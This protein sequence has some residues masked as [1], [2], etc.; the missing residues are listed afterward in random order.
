LVAVVI[1][2]AIV[3]SLFRFYLPDVKAYRGEI[4]AFASEVLEQDVRIDS[5]DAK[6]S[7]I[8]PLIT[9]NNVYLLDTHTKNEIV[10]FEQARLTIDLLRS[11]LKMEVVPDSFT[12][13]GVDLGVVRKEDGNFTIQG[14]EIDQLGDQITL[15]ADEEESDELAKWFFQRS[16]LAIK[17][18]RVVFKNDHETDKSIQLDNVNFYL[19]NDGDRHQLTGTVTLP[20]ELGRDLEIAFDFNGNILN[21]SQWFGKVYYQAND[22][23]LVNWGVKP[24]FMFASLEQ[25]MLDIKLW[26]DWKA[27]DITAF[28]ADLNAS[29]FIVNVGKNEKPF[30]IEKLD[31]LV[32]WHTD[33]IGWKLNVKDFQYK[34]DNEVWPASKLAVRYAKQEELIS[35]YSSFLRLEDIKR[36]LIDGKILDDSLKEGLIKIDPSGDLHH[37]YLNYS[38]LEDY[39]KFSLVSEFDGLTL[40]PWGQFPGIENITGKVW[41]NETKGQLKLKSDSAR[42]KI[43][44]IFRENLDL[45]SINGSIDWHH[46]NKAWHLNSRD[47]SAISPDI[48]ANLGFYAMVPDNSASPYLDLQVD[49]DNGNAKQ[50]YKY[51]PVSVMDEELVKWLDK[52]F[53]SGQVTSGGVVFNGR[54]DDFPFRDHSGTLLAD[55]NAKNVNLNY[56]PGWPKIKVLDANL[57]ITGL[58]L[59]IEASN[60]QIYDSYLTDTRVDIES[61][62]A[63]VIK[64]SSKYQGQTRDLAR[65]LVDT[66]I[67]PKA[68]SILDELR[69]SGKSTGNGAL[70]LPLSDKTQQSS[71]F[72]YQADVELKNNELDAWQ[73]VLQVKKITGDLRIKQEGI[74]SDNLRFETLGGQSQAKLYTTTLNDL[75]NIKLSM[76]GEIDTGKISEHVELSMLDRVNGKT[77]WQGILAIG[78]QESPGYFQFFSRLDGVELNLP[79]PLVKVA[80]SEKTLN[81]TAQFPEEEKLPLNIKYGDELSMALIVNLKKGQERP[82]DKGEIIFSF[83][84]EGAESTK[85]QA[86]LPVNNE[87]LIRGRLREFHLDQWLDL[88]NQGDKKQTIGITSLNI[89]VRLDMEYLK[90]LTGDA[91]SPSTERKDPRNIAIFDGDI[92]AFFVNDMHLGH[93]KFKMDRHE[94]G[95]LFKEI[96]VDAPYMQLEG[97]GSWLYRDAKHVTNFL[98]LISTEDLGTMLSKLGYSA[99]M[100]KGVSKAV[101]QAHWFDT[102]DNFSIDKLN[103]SIG[104]IIDDGVLSDVKPGAGRM[105]G[106]FSLAELP[107]RLLLDFSELKQG[108]AF[109][110]IVGQINISEGDAYAETLKIISPIALITIEGRTGLAARDFDQRVVVVPSVSGTLPVISWIAWGG[111]I[112]AL[113]FLLEQVFG[114]Q[115]DSSIATEYTITGSWDNPEIRKIEKAP[116][117]VFPEESANDSEEDDSY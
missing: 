9:F 11:L 66:P 57:E 4:E 113:A 102:P 30:S 117:E 18:S 68:Q 38:F 98:T 106:L 3:I 47:I 92:R 81:V 48:N 95:L 15:T 71:P 35:A 29:D 45:S 40:Q 90:I 67:A 101:I 69:I 105:L 37:A 100:Q 70:R 8:T 109:K 34:G 77:S 56:Q 87:L 97:E 53:E 6:L 96:I 7:G 99:V 116:T 93:V 83:A 49:F 22:L 75:Q 114:E 72:H 89:P 112:G 115:F 26:G 63:P 62:K 51:L 16:K 58:G 32:D 46:E 86:N 36:A 88:L 23:N 41:T 52:A 94:D 20:E 13:I 17:D 78:N 107:R 19:R 104:I 110:Q 79:A 25:G 27:G 42:L 84:E 1:A 60:S 65:F 2:V 103:G 59:S 76:H 50:T 61:F 108:F 31:A 85:Q 44:N 24:E 80:N 74:F 21:P 54:L 43:P 5:M 73:R 14:L 64:A 10:H 28:A 82:L 39:D 12:V 111:Q 91:E 55:F 33:E